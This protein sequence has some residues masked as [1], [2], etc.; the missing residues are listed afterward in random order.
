MSS[1]CARVGATHMATSS[2]TWRTLSAASGGCSDTLKP[3]SAGHRADRLDA[4]EVGKREDGPLVRV[5][6]FDAAHARMGERAAHERHILHAGEMQIGNELAA[7]AQQAIVFLA[8]E[9]VRRRP[10]LSSPLAPAW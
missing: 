5:G 2:P 8:D 1:A 9:G 4:G 3:R 6:N 10:A 7:P